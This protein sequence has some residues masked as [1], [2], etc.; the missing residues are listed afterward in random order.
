MHEL[1]DIPTPQG[2]LTLKLVTRRQDTNLYG[3]IPG[4]WLM[5][6]MDQAAELAAGRLARGRTATV[7]TEGMDFLCP[8]RVGAMVNIF[9]QVREVGRSSIKLD[10]E[11][12]IRPP[13]ERDP[14]ER[15]K[16]TEARFV[17]VALDDNGRIRPVP[18]A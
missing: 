9:T 15:Y 12:W 3:D 14:E 5:A 18:E 13:H 1:D 8:V 10:V 6:Q 11:V 2:E 16:V 7:A 4:G 17:M